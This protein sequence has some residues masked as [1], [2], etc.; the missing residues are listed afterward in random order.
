MLKKHFLLLKLILLGLFLPWVYGC[1]EGSS[2][3]SGGSSLEGGSGNASSSVSSP[4]TSTTTTAPGSGTGSL[5]ARVHQ[6]EPTTLLLL[7]S[8]V[9]TI[10]FFKRPKTKR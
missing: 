6:P 9:I 10:A 7:G 5:I 4:S 3:L 1:L 2:Q 8:G